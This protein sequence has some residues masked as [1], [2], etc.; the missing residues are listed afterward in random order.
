MALGGEV[1]KWATL[2]IGL[3]VLALIAVAFF[4]MVTRQFHANGALDNATGNAYPTLIGLVPTLLII[5]FVV[6]LVLGIVAMLKG[7]KRR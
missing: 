7:G 4:P 1:H 3:V 6:G 2:V 5:I